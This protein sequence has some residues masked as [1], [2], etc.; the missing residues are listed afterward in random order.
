MWGE[1]P[2]QGQKWRGGGEV[3][4]KASKSTASALPARRKDERAIQQRARDTRRRIVEAA[5]EEFGN[6]GYEGA[7]TRAVAAA[8][9]LQHTLITYHF[10]SKEGLWR[11]AIG[12]LLTDYTT[13]YEERLHGLR[14]VDDVTKLRLILEDFIRLSVQNLGLHRMMHHVAGAPSSQLDW[15][16]EEYLR[17]SFDSRADLI[18]SAQRQGRFVE[19]DPYHLEYVFIGAVTRILMLASEVEKIMGRSPLDP[20]FLDE[21]VRICL[22]LF[23][24]DPS[25]TR[26]AKPDGSGTA[27]P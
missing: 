12:S 20:D 21:H 4:V 5:I 11:A 3:L 18:R 22:G 27:A 10:N 7:S 26:D 19:G 25:T 15:L 23:F 6:H 13:S 17:R 2:A 1:S 16:V 14:G 8:A 24:R 9:G